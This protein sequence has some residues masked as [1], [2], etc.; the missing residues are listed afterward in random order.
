MTGE[1]SIL[2]RTVMRPGEDQE[3]TRDARYLAFANA[4]EPTPLSDHEAVTV[5]PPP[6]EQTRAAMG[7]LRPGQMLGQYQIV[8]QLGSGGMGQVFK[9]LHPAM[10]RTVA[11]KVIAPELTQDAQT[12]AR[13]R[14]E[15]RSAARLHHPN[16]VVA[17]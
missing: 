15:V 14:R 7:Q 2:R 16:V 3:A 12:R 11:L 1:Q 10:G 6:L 5:P 13:F 9:A 8:E 17:H 4:P